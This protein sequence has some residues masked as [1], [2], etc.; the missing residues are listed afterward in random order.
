MQIFQDDE[1]QQDRD[2]LVG[3]GEEGPVVV[4]F[5][6]AADSKYDKNYLLVDVRDIEDYSQC[7]IRNA[8]SLPGPMIRS[9]RFPSD[10]YY[11]VYI[12][13]LIS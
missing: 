11:Y 10:F 7:H 9:D 8:I 12:T 5:D 13:E 1:E 2:N 3:D 4:V 6:A